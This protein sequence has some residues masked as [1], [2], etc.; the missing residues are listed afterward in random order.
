MNK[1]PENDYIDYG[2]YIDRKKAFIISLNHL[3]HEAFM[4]EE[5]Q[6]NEAENVRKTNVNQQEHIQNHKNEGLRKFCRS[7]ILKLENAHRILIFGPSMS[8]FELQNELRE[9][10][11]LKYVSEELHVSD[12]M[13]K[14]AALRF[15]KDHYTLAKV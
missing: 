14:D 1:K 11:Q 6:E 3:V 5:T 4:D 7:I 10:K 15:V 13:D 2:V 9:N 12:I 8:K